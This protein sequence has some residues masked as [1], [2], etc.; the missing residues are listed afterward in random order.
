MAVLRERIFIS[1]GSNLDPER[2]IP[3]ALRLL[4]GHSR[5][6]ALS[7]FYA[8]PAEGDPDG[9]PFVNGAAEIATPLEPEAVKWELLRPV[10]EALGRTRSG[11]RNAPRTIDL[12][13]LLYGDR[14][15]D[16][17]R[18]TLPDPG[19]ARY[20]FVAVPLL[21]LAPGLTLP[22]AGASLEAEVRGMDIRTLRPLTD[23]TARWR[24][25]FIRPGGARGSGTA[26]REGS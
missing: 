8:C 9:P 3:E 7:T 20:P 21:E 15:M 16:T 14:T 1:I 19:I 11:D 25:A 4:S 2:H 24:G 5:V 22:G 12:D 23:L 6:L 26:R 13:L 17:P 18:L 10:E